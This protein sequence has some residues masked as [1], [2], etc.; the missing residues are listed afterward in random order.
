MST[1]TLPRDDTGATLTRFDHVRGDRYAEIFLVGGDTRGEHLVA[2]I[3]NTQGRNTPSGGGDTA[4]QELLQGLDLEALARE[5]GATGAI[6]NGPRRWCLDWL[7]V[8]VGA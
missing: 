5:H 4:P 6:L 2:A 3:Y 7:D 1:T 8:M